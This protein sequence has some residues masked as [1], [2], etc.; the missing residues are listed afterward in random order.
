MRP[1][2]LALVVDPEALRADWVRELQAMMSAWGIQATA[3]AADER[4]DLALRAK[5]TEGVVIAASRRMAAGEIQQLCELRQLPY[6]GPGP[7]ACSL[8]FDKVRSRQLLAYHN[9]PV[10][11]AVALGK[12]RSVDLRAVELLGWPCVLK[13]RRGSHGAGVT[14]IEAPEEVE[15]AVRC[16]LELDAELVLERAV[17]GPELQVVLFDDRVVG[18]MERNDTDR[19]IAL[20]CPPSCSR[21]RLDGITNLARAA[22][23][24]LG[25]D[26]GFSRVDILSSPRHNEVVL[27]VEACPPIDGD[28]TVRRIFRAMGWSW[29]DAWADILRPVL[30]V[31]RSARA[32]AT[33]IVVQ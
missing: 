26:R 33:R 6:T 25:V 1:Y 5:H 29:A 16:A 12:D 14:H 19:G 30:E 27:E 11:A 32:G 4:L 15:A 23:T 13:P 17:D 22:V 20:Q 10:P 24:A 7:A 21:A 18:V 28:S 3:L 2:A 8:A 9:L 31:A